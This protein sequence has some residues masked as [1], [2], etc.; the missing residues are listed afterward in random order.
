MWLQPSQNFKDLLALSLNLVLS[1]PPLC[2]SFK[3]LTVFQSLSRQ[4]F[5]VFSSCTSNYSLSQSEVQNDCHIYP[6]YVAILHFFTFFTL[7]NEWVVNIPNIENKEELLWNV[8]IL[9]LC[10]VCLLLDKG[11]EMTTD[12]KPRSVIMY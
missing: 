2:A 5:F 11:Q 8:H 9:P 4:G 12:D 6:M 7:P 1:L 10:E 3:V